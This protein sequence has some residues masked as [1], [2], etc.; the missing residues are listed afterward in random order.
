MSWGDTFNRHK[1][2]GMDPSDAAFRADQSEPM[3]QRRLAV[4]NER[5]R[6][7]LI[8]A[9][10]TIRSI[11]G[12]DQSDVEFIRVA[13]GE[14]PAPS[15]NLRVQEIV[16]TQRLDQLIG[17]GDPSSAEI[18]DM[19]VE[20]LNWRRSAPSPASS[21]T[22]LPQDVIDLVIAAREFWDV[23][24]DLSDESQALDK[25]LEP[26]AERVPYENEPVANTEGSD[27]G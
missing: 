3:R 2:T 4:E 20:L 23:N 24:N 12:K 22:G 27:R 26:F 15:V 21:V 7:A 6:E 11:P 14:I 25:A 13:L 17:S 10:L 19:A 16:P 5:L 8:Q 9:D 18:H 1:A